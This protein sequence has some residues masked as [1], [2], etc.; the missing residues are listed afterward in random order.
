MSGD[1]TTYRVETVYDV[2][3]KASAKLNEID[4]AARRAA[5]STESLKG[6]MMG[7]G[8]AIAGSSMLHLAK[9]AFIDFNATVESSKI[10][11]ATIIG[12]NFGVGWDRATQSANRM[13][14]EFVKFSQTLPVTTQEL[15]K[16]SV[17]V[18]QAVASNGGNIKDMI[19]I[20]EQGVVAAKALGVESGYAASELSHMLAGNVNNRM[21]FAKNLIGMTGMSLE[22]WRKLDAS[23]RLDLTKKML[24]SDTM[25]AATAAFGQSFAGVTSTLEDKLQI[26]G[27]KIGLPLFKA[28][29]KE[30]GNWN[31]YLDSHSGAIERWA[32]SVG[33]ALV[34]GFGYV[35]S[36]VG[37]MVDHSGVLIK[38]AEAWALMKLGRGL[39]G[40]IAGTL[41]GFGGGTGGLTKGIM[42]KGG[43]GAMGAI[44]PA[45]ASFGLGYGI[46]TAI[47]EY[48]GASHKIAEGLALMTGRIDKTTIENDHLVA[49]MKRFDEAVEDT[50]GRLEKMGGSVSTAQY[51]LTN[52]LAGNYRELAHS[53]KSQ[54]FGSN[55]LFGGSVQKA[56]VEMMK[57]SMMSDAKQK[58]LAGF[59]PRV[60]A[61]FMGAEASNLEGKANAAGLLTDSLIAANMATL[62]ETQKQSVDVQK[63]TKEIFEKVFRGEYVGLD[64]R[65]MLLG[66]D[67]DALMKSQAKI[68]QTVNININQ[69]T[70]KDPGRW[71]A[72][73]DD[74]AAKRVRART[75]PRSA[76]AR[77]H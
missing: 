46:G 62:N 68:N 44:G 55:P 23:K 59:D 65:S 8:A 35:K 34:T 11:L 77:G 58:M 32:K 53:L 13:Y 15:F 70:A 28:I 76:P 75:R 73:L 72:D 10:G 26:L 33:E 18:D 67:P 71:L 54:A 74:Y 38:I 16:F 66:T 5:H 21:M 56:S 1:T 43:V 42:S 47:N 69:V 12:A 61:G 36:A 29:T 45:F 24:N 37:F 64:I 6:L 4:H 57:E 51:A 60:V 30:I 9:K 17:G 27:G 7:A 22:Q 39:G 50:S 2:S 63:A 49:A 3:D 41:G 31:A 52:T 40:A 20:S 48:T 19:N 25:K 14:G